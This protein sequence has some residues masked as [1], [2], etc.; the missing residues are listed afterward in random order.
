M[1][2][3]DVQLFLENFGATRFVVDDEKKTVYIERRQVSEIT[4]SWES[5]LWFEFLRD[6]GDYGWRVVEREHIPVIVR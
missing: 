2:D 5:R 1:D 4:N 6:I 3:N